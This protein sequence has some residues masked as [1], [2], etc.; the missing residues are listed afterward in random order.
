MKIAIGADHKGF[1]IKETIKSYL[2]MT[3]HVVDD[4]GTY[5][6]ESADFSDFAIKTA[7]AVVRKGAERGI[8]ICMTG[9]GMAIAANKVRGIRAG[10]AL[11]REMAALTRSHNDANILV[12]SS[13]FTPRDEMVMIVDKFLST[14]FEGG[15]HKRRI[16]KIKRY[17]AESDVRRT[18]KKRS[19]NL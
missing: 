14:K 13:R 4:F 11:N 7:D 6:E 8:L 15:R 12:L 1:G 9:N 18:K 17:E 16:D 2:R 5:S 3:G 19:R 10:L